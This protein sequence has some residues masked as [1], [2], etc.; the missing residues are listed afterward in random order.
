MSKVR[1]N[2]NGRMLAWA[3]ERAGYSVDEL[4]GKA[5]VPAWKLELWEE[6]R[7]ERDSDRPTVKQVRKLG[8]VLRRPLVFFFL[9][10][11]PRG[12]VDPTKVKDFRRLSGSTKTLS[13][14][15]RYAIR[16][17]FER[18]E[19]AL[20]LAAGL[21]VSFERRPRIVDQRDVESSALAARKWLGVVFGEQRRGSNEREYYNYWREALNRK[22]ILVFQFERVDPSECRGFAIGKWPLPA[23][24][25]NAKDAYHVRLFTLLHELGHCLLDSGAVLSAP[26][27]RKVPGEEKFCNQFAAAVLMPEKRVERYLSRHRLQSE[28]EWDGTTLKNLAKDHGVSEEVALIRMID[29]GHADAEDYWRRRRAL[30]R[31]RYAEAKKRRK[32]SG[33]IRIPMKYRLLGTNGLAYSNLVIRALGASQI[34]MTDAAELLGGRTRHVEEVAAELARKGNGW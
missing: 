13:P 2:I 10:E 7:A 16:L 3:R 14:E 22:R 34:G 9:H 11:P 4:A 15:L 6:N 31:R 19:E 21:N 32:S 5:R 8:K 12:E 18:R 17:A 33:P 26:L 29:L 30:F 24:S 27:R 25:V 1:A 20:Q 23:I 28:T